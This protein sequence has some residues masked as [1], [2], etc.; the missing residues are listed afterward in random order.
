MRN[1]AG[2]QRKN[3]PATKFPKENFR[4]DMPVFSREKIFFLS[5]LHTHM[6]ANGFIAKDGV[7]PFLFF[8]RRKKLRETFIPKAPSSGVF[9][10][11]QDVVSTFPRALHR[12]PFATVLW[13]FS[14][15]KIFSPLWREEIFLPRTRCD[16]AG[17][18]IQGPTE[19]FGVSF[20]NFGGNNRLAP[21]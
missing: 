12:L 2:E 9:K 15:K 18:E 5:L 14:P 6:S 16:C 1:Q 7:A 4:A 3:L 21:T 19:N 20:I 17:M 10:D 8:P 11:L 13:A